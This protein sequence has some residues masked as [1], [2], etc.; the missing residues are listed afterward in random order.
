MVANSGEKTAINSGAS[1]EGRERSDKTLSNSCSAME[2]DGRIGRVIGD[3]GEA[4]LVE[5]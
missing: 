3:D 1:S 5:R 4:L 2:E